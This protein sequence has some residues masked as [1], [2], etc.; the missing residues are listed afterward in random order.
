MIDVRPGSPLSALA[1]C[2]GL[3]LSP[4]VPAEVSSAGLTGAGLSSAGLSS[5]GQ[6][7]T[8]QSSAYVVWVA[9]EQSVESVVGEL[10]VVATSRFERSVSG[11][12]AP[13]TAE[14]AQRLRA[15]AGVLGV[16]PDRTV[17]ATETTGTETEPDPATGAGT[18]TEPDPSNR[19]GTA[20]EPAQ[21]PGDD[22]AGKRNRQTDPRN[23]GLDR[24]DQRRL[25]LSRSYS[26]DAT[27]A[28]VHV[29][30]LDTGIDL[31]HPEFGG[32]ARFE[33]NIAGGPPGDCG[34]HGT[35]VAGIAGGAK[36]GV[37]KQAILHDVKV[38]D[39]KGDGSLSDLVEGVEWVTRNARRPAV[40][41]LS[42]RYGNK[43][44]DI[45]S[46]A[47][48]RLADA[49]VFVATSAGNT[50]AD[51]CT[52]APRAARNVLVVA[53]STI[54]DRRS[55]TSSTGRCVSL[56]APGTVIDAPVPGGGIAPYTG[57]S[58]SAP[59]A[60]GVAA[61]YKQRYGDAPT[62]AVRKWLVDRA[63]PDVLTGGS[64]GGTA[65]LLLYTGGL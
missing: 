63:T 65:N 59:F 31:R 16:E 51:S 6:F 24:I 36:L 55:G 62:A 64:D 52:V 10:G 14:Q 1:A 30:V 57:T 25:P 4:S 40:A 46:A 23:W 37:A 2:L 21:P 44:S 43:P 27:G 8:G 9:P 28:G 7:S 47:V 20:T 19:P 22:S 42:W 49:G 56:Y 45:L 54:D 33:V 35:V 11:F 29:Y 39:C 32:R 58:M 3:L 48:T 18:A 61:M 60:A 17:R 15:R 50:G 34:G 41:V 5:A 38:L 26:T 53:N 13:L 12:A